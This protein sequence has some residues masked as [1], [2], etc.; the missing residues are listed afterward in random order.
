MIG[1]SF[2]LIHF[3]QNPVSISIVQPDGAMQICFAKIEM[4]K[5][6]MI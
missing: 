5:S 2:T 3:G 1:S 4:G 6:K